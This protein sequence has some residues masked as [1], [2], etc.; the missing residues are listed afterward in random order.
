MQWSFTT[1]A[2]S[3]SFQII[4]ASL[5]ASSQRSFNFKSTSFQQRQSQRKNALQRKAENRIL[6]FAIKLCLASGSAEATL[7]IYSYRLVAHTNTPKNFC[8]IKARNANQ[9]KIRP[10]CILQ[11]KMVI[12]KRK[13]I[14]AKIIKQFLFMKVKWKLYL[15]ESCILSWFCAYAVCWIFSRDSFHLPNVW[16]NL[17][18]SATNAYQMLANLMTFTDNRAQPYAVRRRTSSQHNNEPRF[19]PPPNIFRPILCI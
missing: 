15:I 4:A 16:P 13:I 11:S 12:W 10:G 14:H 9:N 8:N 18:I 19:P 17:A 2:E 3:S 5:F 7:P 1:I 6:N